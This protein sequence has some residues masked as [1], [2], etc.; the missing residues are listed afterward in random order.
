MSRTMYP[1]F[2]SGSLSSFRVVISTGVSE[3]GGP[4]RFLEPPRPQEARDV[5]GTQ[6]SNG[7]S[8]VFSKVAKRVLSE[9]DLKLRVSNEIASQ[10][11][12]RCLVKRDDADADTR[13]PFQR[14]R[15]AARIYRLPLRLQAD[16]RQLRPECASGHDFGYV[17]TVGA[18]SRTGRRR[19]RLNISCRSP[20]CAS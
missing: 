7:K 13:T 12:S 14:S 1:C 16:E 8:K 2:E 19:Q 10:W 15:A 9:G 3:P 6:V 20:A 11:R 18:A 17:E 5:S 4:Y